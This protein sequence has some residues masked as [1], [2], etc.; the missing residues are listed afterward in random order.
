MDSERRAR[1]ISNCSRRKR[2][3]CSSNLGVMIR[4]RLRSSLSN[5]P[6]LFRQSP[7]KPDVRLYNDSEAKWVWKIRESGARAAAAAPGAPPEWEGWD[8]AAVAPEKVSAYLRDIRKLLDEYNYQAAFYGHFGHGCI[9]MRVSFD[10]ESESGIR[11]Y[12]EFVERAADLVVSY[13]GSLSGEHG[14]GQSRGALLPKMFGPELVKAFGEFK[15]A[16]DPEN[17]MNPQQGR[18]S[19]IYPRKISG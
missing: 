13:G 2:A 9:H 14:D 17:K 8:D 19:L 1:P 12:G 6:T 16:W 10:L 18:E 15:A 7:G 3:S 5:S 4:T 11:N